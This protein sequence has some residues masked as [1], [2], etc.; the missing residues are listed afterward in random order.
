MAYEEQHFSHH[1]PL[2]PLE[3]AD[4]DGRQICNG[5]EDPITHSEQPY[6]GCL[7]CCY[8]FHERC[9]QTPRSLE[10]PSHPN[11]PLTLHPTPTYSTHSFTCDACGSPGNAFSF[12]CAH[13]EFDLHLQCA[14]LPCSTR[15]PEDKHPHELKLCFDFR[16]FSEAMKRATVSPACVS[17]HGKL[18]ENQWLYRCEECDIG[19]HLQCAKAD[20]QC[21]EEGGEFGEI[22]ELQRLH[23][24]MIDQEMRFRD[25]YMKAEQQRIMFN[26]M[27]QCISG[28]RI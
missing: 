4:A 22:N 12:G 7:K 3:L 21:P 14:A 16:S 19:I 11:H 23:N 2:V 25:Y 8:V 28:S 17:C 5:C 1:H 6:K 20:Q 15:L 27:N 9:V 24:K 18:E 10:H 13:C 26:F